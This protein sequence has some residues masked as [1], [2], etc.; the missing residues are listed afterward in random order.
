MVMSSESCVQ[1]GRMYYITFPRRSVTS[2]TVESSVE[3]MGH[4]EWWA[5]ASGEIEEGCKPDGIAQM[6]MCGSVPALIQ[7]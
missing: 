2:G 7:E 5:V 6:A 1:R 3:W 4:D